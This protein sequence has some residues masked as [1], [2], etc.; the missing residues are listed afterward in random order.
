MLWKVRSVLGQQVTDAITVQAWLKTIA[1]A[2]RPSQDKEVGRKFG[3][4]LLAAAANV[5]V[6]S[7]DTVGSILAERGFPV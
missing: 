2:S 6:E 1:A 3:N 7:R 4:A 5:S